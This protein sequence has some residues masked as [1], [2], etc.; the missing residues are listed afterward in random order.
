MMRAEDEEKE[1]ADRKR[2]EVQEELEE[3]DGKHNEGEEADISS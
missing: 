2:G 1:K 3:T